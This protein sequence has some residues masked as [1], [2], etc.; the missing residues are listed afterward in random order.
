MSGSNIFMIYSDGKGNVTVSPR[1]GVGNT[2]P[3]YTSSTRITVL[4]GTK[5]SSDGSMTANFRCDNCMSWS[6]GSMRTTGSSSWIWASQS[7]ASI[8]STDKSAYLQLH[9]SRAGFTMDLSQATGGSSANPFLSSGT[10]STGAT[11]T[12]SGQLTTSTGGSSSG[13]SSGD[14]EDGGD[15]GGGYSSGTGSGSGSGTSSTSSTAPSGSS[16]ISGTDSIRAIHAVVMS[17]LFVLFFPLF[18]LT[19]YLRTTKKVR[20]IHA[21]LQAMSIIFLVIGLSTGIILGKNIGATTGTHEVLGYFIVACLVFIQPILGL[22]QHLYYHKTHRRS[23]LGVCHQW[24]GRLVILA[25]VVNGGLGFKQTSSMG[26]TS[27][28]PL[29]AVLAYSIAAI[30]VFI[31]YVN[32]VIVSKVQSRS[33]QSESPHK[34]PRSDHEMQP[35]RIR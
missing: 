9:D 22:Y 35:S 26:L 25:G 34:A 5:S 31:V 10:G 21:P 7:G 16:G 19:L 18:A 11:T 4:E 17:V 20:Y 32:V 28:V 12:S 27:W 33:A 3:S 6:G 13:G 14:G 8:D 23:A 24:L 15:D 1:L 2:E 30:I 29:W